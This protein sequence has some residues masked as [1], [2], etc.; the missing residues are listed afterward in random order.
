M[1]FEEVTK[2]K[3]QSGCFLWAFIWWPQ[4]LD[5]GSWNGFIMLSLFWS[6]CY[7]PKNLANHII[8][9]TNL[10]FMSKEKR[11]MEL[12]SHTSHFL[13]CFSVWR[14]RGK[15][16]QHETAITNPERDDGGLHRREF[17]RMKRSCSLMLFWDSA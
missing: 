13:L 5:M 15:R 1:R 11:V 17:Y 14:L 4:C 12:N 8:T 9:E 10:C 6:S 2:L 7:M 16:R 3:M